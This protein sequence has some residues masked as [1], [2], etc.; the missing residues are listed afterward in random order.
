LPWQRSSRKKI[1]DAHANAN[2]T[3]GRNIPLG[4]LRPLDAKPGW[5]SSLLEHSRTSNVS[6]Y[7]FTVVAEEKRST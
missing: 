3:L 6:Q 7:R 1:A 4:T 5:R 2:V